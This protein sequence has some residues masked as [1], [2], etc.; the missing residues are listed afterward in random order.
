LRHPHALRHATPS[1]LHVLPQ[2]V[3]ATSLSAEYA[4]AAASFSLSEAQLLALAERS[5][6]YVFGSEAD[7]AALAQRLAAFR[8]A[9]ER[10]GGDGQPSATAQ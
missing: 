5:V 7:R 8:A 9:W 3:F 10:G 4:L 2:G 6:G 1:R